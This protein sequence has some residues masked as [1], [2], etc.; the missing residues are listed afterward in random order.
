MGCTQSKDGE[1]S[2]AARRNRE[3]QRALEQDNK[4]EQEKIK[5]LLLGPGESGKSTIFRQMKLIY[6]VISEDDR[7]SLTPVVYANTISTIKMVIKKAGFYGFDKQVVDQDAMGLIRSLEDQAP[8]DEK[9]GQ[10][11]TA[12]WEDPMIQKTWEKR[13][14][15]QVIESMKYFLDGMSRI[16]QPQYVATPQD[17]LH[18]RIRSSGIVVDKYC[19]DGTTFEMYDVGGQRNERKKWIHC[20]DNVTAVIYVAALSEYNQGMFEDANT[21]RMTEAVN[22]FQGIC[23]NSYFE[24][25]SI[26]LFLNKKDLFAEKLATNPIN[27]TK[28][29]SDFKGA[30]TFD[31]GVS[32]FLEKA[33]GECGKR[34]FNAANTAKKTVYHHV[35]CATDSENIEVVFNSCKDT[36]LR[37]N[38]R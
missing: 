4:T 33:S 25:S 3:L 1:D 34:R 21:N 35:T 32:Y 28:E 22:L 5:L 10:A 26:I 6:G 37:I 12:L 19:I 13:S 11:I 31:R 27:H 15:Y 30:C 16:M 20:F 38:F 18:I 9:V 29:W 24:R 2:A 8:I 14:E 7:V 17:I 36:V 23:S